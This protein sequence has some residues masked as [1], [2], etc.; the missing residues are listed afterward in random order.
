MLQLSQTFLTRY[1][2]WKFLLIW[3]NRLNPVVYLM[4]Y[5][6]TK[7]DF[8]WQRPT[9]VNLYHSQKI[10]SSLLYSLH[11]LFIANIFICYPLLKTVFASLYLLFP[12]RWGMHHLHFSNI[13]NSLTSKLANI[14]ITSPLSFLRG[15]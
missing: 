11:S 7:L 3:E 8:V 4:F 12:M 13:P 15:I 14:S 2:N 6:P 10:R 1:E 5:P 9:K